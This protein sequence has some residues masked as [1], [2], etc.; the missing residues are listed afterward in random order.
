MYGQPRPAKNPKICGNDF[1]ATTNFCK[2][3]I[4]LNCNCHNQKAFFFNQT[5]LHLYVVNYVEKHVHSQNVFNE[6]IKSAE[7]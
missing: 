7:I 3:N 4:N 5:D 1:F 6:I 2:K